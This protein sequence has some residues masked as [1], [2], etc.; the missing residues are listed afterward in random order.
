MFI[1]FYHKDSAQV[2]PRQCAC[3]GV[4]LEGA[5]RRSW[6]I[7]VSSRTDPGMWAAVGNFFCLHGGLSLSWGAMGWE[8][9]WQSCKAA[10][11]H[12]KNVKQLG[13]FWSGVVR[14][15]CS[16]EVSWEKDLAQSEEGET[17]ERLGETWERIVGK[18]TSEDISQKKWMLL[19]KLGM[20]MDRGHLFENQMWESGAKKRH[21][22]QGTW[23][24]WHNSQHNGS[25][26]C[27][28][29]Y[30]RPWNKQRT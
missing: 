19:N 25:K 16:Q 28:C 13:M 11:D 15:S 23:I 2:R 14:K 26:Q 7:V 29:K 21:C 8:L 4:V 27:W 6:W 10:L 22:E 12:V 17:W 20:G 1:S 3:G 30:K 5:A 18:K 24:L 9:Y